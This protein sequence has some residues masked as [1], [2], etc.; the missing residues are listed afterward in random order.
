MDTADARVQSRLQLVLMVVVG[1]LLLIEVGLL[2]IGIYLP[3]KYY[4]SGFQATLNAQFIDH[5][6]VLGYGRAFDFVFLATAALISSFLL[7]FTG[8]FYV[9]RSSS[10]S[11]D[12]SVSTAAGGGNLKTSS[13]GLAMI[14]MGVVLVAIIVINESS[15]SY[16]QSAGSSFFK[17]PATTLATD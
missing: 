14:A 6:A 4:T 16:T 10:V 11:F 3:W 1:L 7:I 15:V 2:M 17:S 12:A 8:A 13:P 5:A 9:L